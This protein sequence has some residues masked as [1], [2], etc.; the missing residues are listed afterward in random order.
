MTTQLTR[1]KVLA[2][3][4]TALPLVA[5]C[6]GDGST[7]VIET[8]ARPTTPTSQTT[9]D[10]TTTEESGPADRNVPDVAANYR[11]A[12]GEWGDCIAGS[13]RVGQYRQVS[14]DVAKR[15]SDALESAGVRRLRLNVRQTEYA[16]DGLDLLLDGTA[17]TLD[18]TAQIL[19]AVRDE[20]HTELVEE[21]GD[22][23][24]GLESV[25][26]VIVPVGGL[27]GGD[28]KEV[29][30]RLRE[31]HGSLPAF[32]DWLRAELPQ[33][34]LIAQVGMPGRQTF[35]RAPEAYWKTV[36]RFDAVTNSVWPPA[37]S[38]TCWDG[39]LSTLRVTFGTL[40]AFTDRTGV[41]FEPTVAPGIPTGVDGCSAGGSR[42]VS[43]NPTGYERALRVGLTYATGDRVSVDSFN[44]WQRGTQIEPG[45]YAGN[46]YGE[47]YLAGTRAVLEDPP[48]ERSRDIYYVA[49][50]GATSGSGSREDPLRS[51]QH[52]LE[53]AEPGETVHLL[54]GR[55][56]ERVATVRAGGPDAPITIT[57]P[58][59]AVYVGGGQSADPEP[60]KIR[61]SH[62][63]VTGLTFDGLQNPDSPDD[64]D[65]YARSNLTVDPI[66]RWHR[67][68]P[69][70]TVRDVKLLPHAVG[71]T[72]GPCMHVF[73]GE[74]IE[75]GECR[76]LGPAGVAH[77]RFDQPGH[78]GEI[79]YIGTS[80]GGW[81]GRWN[82]HVDRTRNVHVHHIDAS[83]GHP[84]AELADAKPGTEDV[85]IE[86]CTSAGSVGGQP[87]IHLGGT[88]GV[89]RWNR[90]E[91]S[92]SD[93]ITVG[94]W[95][96]ESD[97]TPDAATGS[98]VYGNHISG[99]EQKALRFT[100]DTSPDEQRVLCGNEVEAPA[101]DDP[102]KTCP[103][104]LP[105]G[106]GVGHTGGDS[107]HA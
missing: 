75:V 16:R 66:S 59:D 61:H 98:A 74:N 64:P 2:A 35:D 85:L 83:A 54:P 26:G 103:A 92:E 72:L 15:H 53:F 43:R 102:T 65:A 23:S 27:R 58:P 13:P 18:L 37:E 63:H 89:A 31:E 49:P 33:V 11:L 40:R 107:P 94:N 24:E 56:R 44:D 50:D 62:V 105:S 25:E 5:G 71:N 73:F 19:R 38:A 69:P 87:G 32:V 21:V 48:I 42:A 34:R 55:Y 91:D 6:Q 79:V 81:E 52:A 17:R 88:D 82:G 46:E 80:Q 84:H 68:G 41:E 78:D 47:A 86:Y 28:A 101:D 99:S 39:F 22:V 104:D 67:D 20:R 9:T 8:S 7:G 14:T 1:R 76:L 70:P 45:T 10:A 29:R 36:A 77:F 90:I 106:D 51:I 93:G 4:T 3:A 57:G 30:D 12:H 97:A 100:P 95:G 96:A 60:M